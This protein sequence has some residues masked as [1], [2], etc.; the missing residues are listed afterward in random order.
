[1]TASFDGGEEIELFLWLSDPSSPHYKP[2]SLA[3][4]NEAVV[5]DLDNPPW[6]TSVVL[7]FG[8][9]DAG[10]DWWWAIDNVKVTG[11]PK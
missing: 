1:M 9:F 4:E 5:V 11:V 10:N 8:L 3:N 2:E 7:T 6:A